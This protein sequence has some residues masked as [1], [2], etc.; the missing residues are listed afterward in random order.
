MPAARFFIVGEGSERAALE[1]LRRDLGLEDRLVLTGFR[2][3]ALEI[4]S[5]FDCFVLSSYLEGL[6]TSIMD[7]QA[8][9]VPVV[10][11][12][13]GG[14]PELVEDGVTGLLVPPRQPDQFAAAILRLLREAPLRERLQRNALEIAPRYDYRH[15]VRKTLAAYGAVAALDARRGT[16]M[17]FGE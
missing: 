6:G 17:N 13:T 7:A 12:R 4:L 9:G 3:D 14:V 15:M 10:A 8:L 16:T 1:A 5:L 11:T 2:E